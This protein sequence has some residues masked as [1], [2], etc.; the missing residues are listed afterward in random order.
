LRELNILLKRAL[1]FVREREHIEGGFTLYKGIPDTKNT[2]YGVKILEMFNIE[3]HNKEKTIEWIQKLQKDRM[4]GIKGVFYRL[5]ILDIF[6][7]KIEVP[8]N[9]ITKLNGKTEF[10]SLELSYYY[11]FISNILELD[12]LSK[13]ADWILS[14]QNEDGGYG[15]HRSEISSTY[16]ALET[17]NFIDPSLIKMKDSIIDFTQRCLTKEGG[18]TFIPDIYPPYLEPTYEG[19]RIQEILAKEPI[20]HN[21]TKEFVQKLQN[22]NGG[23]RRSKYLGISELEYTFKSLYILKSI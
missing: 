23:F 15:S 3:P 16:Y 5:N 4:Y 18:F 1:N 22:S 9:Y 12:N 11:A 2:Y 10:G 17:L 8:E 21:K 6:D 7:V 19:I 13:I 14:H 20:N